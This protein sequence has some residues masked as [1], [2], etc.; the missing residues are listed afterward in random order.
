MPAFITDT[1]EVFECQ[2]TRCKDARRIFMLFVRSKWRI[3]G[4]EMKV[5]FPVL[6]GLDMMELGVHKSN[7]KYTPHTH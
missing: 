6:D 7:T 4:K 5:H 3:M 2:P 1:L